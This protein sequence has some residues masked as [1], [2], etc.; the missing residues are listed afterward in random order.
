MSLPNFLR[1]YL[2]QTNLVNGKHARAGRR[3]IDELGYLRAAYR[4]RQPF[5]VAQSHVG[6]GHD[7]EGD[8]RDNV[9]HV[10]FPR[11]LANEQA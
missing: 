9:F 5:A 10:A 2:R 1:L 8:E 6:A 11:G 3:V 7:G 4:F